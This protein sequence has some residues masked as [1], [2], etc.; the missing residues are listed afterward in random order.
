MTELSEIRQPMVLDFFEYPGFHGCR[1]WCDLELI[2]LADGWTAVI[3]TERAGNPGT[4][5]TNIAEHLASFVC[6]HFGIDPDR[7]VWIEHY[8][9]AS[10][11][12]PERTFDLVTFVRLPPGS[13]SWSVPPGETLSREVPAHFHQPHWRVMTDADWRDLGLPVRKPVRYE[14]RRH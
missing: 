7:L 11:T 5:V 10:T 13:V 2:P 3:A 6:N 8:A 12:F 4:S 14:S 1:S 9:Y